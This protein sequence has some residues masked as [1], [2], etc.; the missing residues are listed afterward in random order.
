VADITYFEVG[1]IDDSYFIY[2]ADAQA[3]LITT[4]AVTCNLGFFEPASGGVQV[5]S[6]SSNISSY[7]W[8]P[9]LY[10]A[11]DSNPVITTFS[12]YQSNNL[13]PNDYDILIPDHG[14]LIL[15]PNDT[16]SQSRLNPL[17]GDFTLEFISANLGNLD[18]TKS[19]AV[20][21]FGTLE[22]FI[23][24]SQTNGAFYHLF[25]V[26]DSTDTQTVMVSN[27]LEYHQVNYQQ[28]K[29]IAL[30]RYGNAF[31]IYIDGNR[32]A[33]TTYANFG[34]VYWDSS[35]TI[36]L[37]GSFGVSNN[38]RSFNE[39]RY[40]NT[41]RY[42]GPTYVQPTSKLSSDQYTIVLS[43]FDNNLLVISENPVI[44]NITSSSQLTANVQLVKLA[45]ASL[46][47]N[48]TV[49]CRLN[50]IEREQ[51]ALSSHSTL[52]ATAKKLV[53]LQANLQAFTSELT[54]AT[55]IEHA[56]A[57]LSSTTQLTVSLVKFNGIGINCHAT[58][59]LIANSHKIARATEHLISQSTLTARLDS[60]GTVKQAQVN[61]TSQT[62]LM[63]YISKF[64]IDTS[65]NWIIIND[66]KNWTIEYENRLWDIP[67]EI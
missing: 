46:S 26:I 54:I 57:N 13:Y 64:H 42:T 60:A 1:Y 48:S 50:Q 58:S 15:V 30:V 55:R 61:L 12:Y 23:Q 24:Y 31:S 4:T 6:T 35:Y 47:S 34:N 22:L 44:A 49:V 9:V 7:T 18:P 65:I 53:Q 29:H 20:L 39:F 19:S 66:N 36:E 33:T 67:T 40:S 27:P 14:G 21:T 28:E 59:S 63:A 32:I 45:N 51:I 17:A 5:P 38:I 25:E 8:Q 62:E 56:V 37:F 2:T 43:H 16:F 3:Q 11:N 41:A 52:T 10:D